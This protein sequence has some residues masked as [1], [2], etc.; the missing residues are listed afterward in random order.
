[1]TDPQPSRF[2]PPPLSI[3]PMGE[4]AW[5]CLPPEGPL[6]IALQ[7]RVHALGDALAQRP[8][9]REVVPGMNNL[10][11][12]F[13]PFHAEA[14][15]LAAAI[16]EEWCSAEPARRS[17]EVFEVPVVYGGGAGEDLKECAA[18]A[19]LSP[20]AF[21]RLHADGEYTVFTLGSHPGFAYL[22]GLD[23][24]IAVPR[25]AVPRHKVAAGAVMIGG[26]QTGVQACD[27]PTG[28]NLIG[29]TQARFFDPA[30]DPPAALRPG[31]RVRFVVREIV[32]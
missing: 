16:A 23:P 31:M 25:R 13:D 30:A 4:A 21:V 27:N 20:E 18:H 7:E 14:D 24:R 3:T 28:W 19:G 32:S 1:M 11:V 12:L 6:D 10:L 29:T 8:E 17:A 9:V 2:S 15:A 26:S 5:L 22:G